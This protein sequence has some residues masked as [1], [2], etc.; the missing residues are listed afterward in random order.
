MRA[1]AASLLNRRGLNAEVWGEKV[2]KSAIQNTISDTSGLRSSKT[3][4]PI[5]GL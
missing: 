5:S 4:L 3:R 2:A 1:I